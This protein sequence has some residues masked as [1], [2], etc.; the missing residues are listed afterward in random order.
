[1][2]IV[3]PVGC[4]RFYWTSNPRATQ[5]PE[6]KDELANWFDLLN[7]GGEGSYPLRIVYAGTEDDVRIRLQGVILDKY[8]AALGGQG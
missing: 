3:D 8:L 4:S 7:S 2:S 1:M 5:V 6:N